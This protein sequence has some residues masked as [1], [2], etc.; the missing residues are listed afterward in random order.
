MQGIE[1]TVHIIPL[2]YEIDRA[3]KPF[4]KTK[5]DRVY[6]LTTLHPSNPDDVRSKDQRHYTETVKRI[7]ED[8]E[9]QVQ[10]V[11]VDLFDLLDVMKEI[12]KIIL[13]EKAN[14]N[15]IFVNMSASGRLTSV[16][17]TLVGMAHD[18]TVYYV[19]AED[20]PV[21]EVLRRDHGLRICS[22][23]DD[24]QKLVNFQFVM[25][26]PIGRQILLH[27]CSER[28]RLKMRDILSVLKK[29]KVEGFEELFD[30]IRDGNKRAEQS[31]QLMKLDRT[32]L[33]KLEKNGW[34]ARE[35]VGR[36]V[37]ISITESGKYAACIS[38]YLD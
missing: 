2:G 17:S 31:R 18:V 14:N 36:T 37:F 5:A 12:S 1:K 38:G 26:D 11:H 23:D 30:E 33:A 25:P 4:E 9:I 6:L 24:I 16:A 19:P 20:Y 21:D 29:E 28:R 8:M 35:K 27:L 10:C 22:P 7:L 32:I 13:R 15:R 34:I 3:V